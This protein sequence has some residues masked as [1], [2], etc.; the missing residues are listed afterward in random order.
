MYMYVYMLNS[1]C[2]S[3]IIDNVMTHDQN[4]INLHFDVLQYQLLFPVCR[5]GGSVD[6]FCDLLMRGLL[7]LST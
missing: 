4:T 3:T 5:D 2:I 7:D 6:V 1:T